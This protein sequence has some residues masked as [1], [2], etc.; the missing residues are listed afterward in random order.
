MINGDCKI[1]S[2]LSLRNN[3][4]EDIS[5][6]SSGALKFLHLESNPK[7][8]IESFD[9]FKSLSSLSLDYSS[10]S[11]PRSS[12]FM[13]QISDVS[14]LKIINNPSLL[15]STPYA[16]KFDDYFMNL[17]RLDL[18][19]LGLKI[20]PANTNSFLLNLRE[21]NLSFNQLTSLEGLKGMPKLTHV[22]LYGN[23]I[24]H[25]NEC[26]DF[27]KNTKN[28][29][30]FDLRENQL[31]RRFY[32]N[33]FECL[34]ITYANDNIAVHGSVS[35]NG[36]NFEDAEARGDSQL[37]IYLKSISRKY[38]AEWCD[39]DAKC[40]RDLEK[41]DTN[42]Y[43]KRIGY[44]GLLVSANKN[45]KWLDGMILDDDRVNMIKKH[46]SLIL[47]QTRKNLA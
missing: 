38:Q 14:N 44:Q 21:V 28:L 11:H 37:K 27:I 47:G 30:L 42:L 31:T 22:L 46:W 17:Q 25:I 26:L 40:L 20:L 4:L 9:N 7:L 15:L 13:G 10:I 24:E 34:N 39:A 45:L 19:G 2:K 12:I 33:L 16:I 1:L 41:F 5:Q 23:N 18:S 3:E 8:Q 32:P 29:T 43:N 36:A 35:H 6:I